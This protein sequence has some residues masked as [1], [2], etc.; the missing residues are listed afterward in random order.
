MQARGN[1]A[2]GYFVRPIL[3]DASLIL[4]DA[5]M[6]DNSKIFLQNKPHV[7]PA[8]RRAAFAVLHSLCASPCVLPGVRELESYRVALHDRAPPAKTP[9][10]NFVET[11]ATSGGYSVIAG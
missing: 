11:L 6:N 8:R 10:A 5:Y 4:T 9:S 2:H 7:Y 1:I 3:T